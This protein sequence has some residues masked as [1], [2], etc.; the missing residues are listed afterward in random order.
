MEK[1]GPRRAPRS[2]WEQT[3]LRAL[4][5]PANLAFAGF[6]GFILALPLVTALPA[7]VAAARSMDGWLREDSTTVFTS[8]FREF[9]ATWRRTLP[10]GVLT[11]VLV[12]IL[13]VD[14]LFLWSQLATGTNGLALAMG[15]ATVPVAISVALMLL[16]LPVAASRNRDGTARQWLVEAAYLVTSRPLR[17]TILLALSAAVT[18]TCVLIPTLVPFFWL[19]VP[20]YLA[21]TSLGAP[22]AV[23]PGPSGPGRRRDR[24]G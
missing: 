18:L 20:A 11:A 24:K 6:A 7:A 16:A 23:P 15:A 10:L 14:V 22:A 12:A 3:A 9:A 19:S 2:G 17:A 13:T 1:P 5:Y 4:A 8:T 21:L